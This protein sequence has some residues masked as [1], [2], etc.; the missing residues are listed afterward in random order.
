MTFLPLLLPHWIQEKKEATHSLSK[1]TEQSIVANLGG[2]QDPFQLQLAFISWS[3]R[4]KRGAGCT[5]R[6]DELFHLSDAPTS[7]TGILRSLSQRGPV[8]ANLWNLRPISAVANI[9]H[10]KF[11]LVALAVKMKSFVSQMLLPPLLGFWGDF[12]RWVH[13]ERTFEI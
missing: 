9:Y 1:I 8:V 10:L 7:S 12:L 5:C 13:L 11:K 3:G 4:D 6:Q 2:I